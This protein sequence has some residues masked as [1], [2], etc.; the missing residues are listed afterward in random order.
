MT[1]QL[2]IGNASLLQWQVEQLSCEFVMSSQ[3]C[4]NLINYFCLSFIRSTCTCFNLFCTL[5]KIA[6]DFWN[7]VLMQVRLPET[8]IY[9]FLAQMF[10]RMGKQLSIFWS[11]AFKKCKI[12]KDG[13]TIFTNLQPSPVVISYT[14]IFVFQRR[15]C[16][17]F[18]RYYVKLMELWLL[19]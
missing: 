2:P 3:F 12:H 1:Q 14:N 18:L 13:Y 6:L 15:K 11:C 19:N 10:K 5:L 17:I 8:C 9:G 16:L 4:R 7:D